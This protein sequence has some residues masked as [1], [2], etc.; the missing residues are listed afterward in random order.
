MGELVLRLY[1]L[2][3]K[4]IQN[5]NLSSVAFEL[6]VPYLTS[7]VSTLWR[8]KKCRVSQSMGPCALMLHDKSSK[9]SRKSRRFI[10]SKA[11]DFEI[12]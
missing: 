3:I 9:H 4:F 5:L 7:R 6:G 10:H 11:D 12:C 1:F 8:P 2:K